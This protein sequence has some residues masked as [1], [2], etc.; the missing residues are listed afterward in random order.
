MARLG[1]LE[2]VDLRSVWEKEDRHF[3]PW[4][5]AE[6]NLQLLGETIGLQLE[7][8]GQEQPVGPFRADL[9]CRDDADH[10]VLIDRKSVV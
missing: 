4:L 6:E 2:R 1:R 3:T 9:L 7:L 5:A 10:L 8:V